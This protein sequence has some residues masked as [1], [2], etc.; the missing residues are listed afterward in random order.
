[1]TGA[2]A[3]CWCGAGLADVA[4][5][6]DFN[7]YDAHIPVRSMAYFCRCTSGHEV[8]VLAKGKVA[9]VVTKAEGARRLDEA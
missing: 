6:F 2:E 4:A 5:D 9:E 7:W 3:R 1:M 8:T